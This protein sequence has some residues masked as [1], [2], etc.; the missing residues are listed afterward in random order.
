V[1]CQEIQAAFLLEIVLQ[2]KL[3]V[4]VLQEILRL[5][6]P[7]GKINLA[8]KSQS[9]QLEQFPRAVLLILVFCT[10]NWHVKNFHVKLTDL[11]Y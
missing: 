7:R 4:F 11:L 9:N 5:R 2:Q 10:L 8:Q 6:L 1:L 3:F